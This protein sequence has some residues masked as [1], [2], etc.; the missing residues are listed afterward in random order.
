MEAGLPHYYRTREVLERISEFL[1][2]PQHLLANFDIGPQAPALNDLIELKDLMS[3]ASA[4]YI[5]AYGQKLLEI[6]QKDH[7]SLK[8]SALGWV[9][10]SAL[11]V[12]RSVWDRKS[13]LV[14]IDIE[15]FCKAYPGEPFLNPSRTFGILEPT[16]QN[17]LHA[18]KRY[19]IS[20]LVITTGQGY[21]L[22]LRISKNSGAFQELVAIGHVEPSLQYDYSHPS[23]ARG[24]SVP[25][26]DGR[27]FDAIGKLVEF[28][29]HRIKSSSSLPPS[30]PPLVIG[31]I[32][33]CNKKRE[34]ISFDLSA[35]GNPLHKRSI[36]CPFSIYSKH[37]LRANI[38]GEVTAKAVGPL[39]CVPRR[40][41]E[42][43][44]PLSKVLDIRKNVEE[45][46]QLAKMVTTQIPHQLEGIRALLEDYQRS[47]LSAFHQD[48]DAVEQDD[49]ATWGEGYD[50]LELRSLAPCVAQVFLCPNPLLLQPTNLQLVVRTLLALGWHPKHIAGLITSKYMRD[51]GWEVN[52][53]R[54][55][56]N[57]WAN[58]WVRLYAGL[59]RCGIDDLGDFDC[60]SQHDRG[61]AW[62]GMQYCPQPQCG[63]ALSDYRQLLLSDTH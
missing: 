18:L 30:I 16:Y 22:V 45:T 29:Y 23:A 42:M 38:Y 1:G 4:E 50:L 56:A 28:L 31:D 13:A 3:A 12:H 46:V 8:C 19:G 39:F 34:A 54:Y 63:F 47:D 48:F 43:E 49:P 35:Y 53:M 27:A 21:N 6:R 41:A 26:A 10:D 15:Y 24:R 17:I 7:V 2:V 55:D 36:R 51:Y 57:R 5:S 37:L 62:R 9:L 60:A 52:F 44:L 58:V 14:F 59:I 25:H 33:C 11:D 61:E 20:P 40:T 32:S